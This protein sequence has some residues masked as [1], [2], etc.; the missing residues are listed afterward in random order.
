LAS[1]LSLST[2]SASVS[3]SKPHFVRLFRNTTGTSPH[4]YVMQKRVERARQLIQ[5]SNV[6][7][8]EIAAE[9][10]FASQSHLGRVFQTTYGITPGDVRKQAARRTRR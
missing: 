4:R 2:L 8:I 5:T 9:V 3:L 7:L 1:D 6:P 10:G